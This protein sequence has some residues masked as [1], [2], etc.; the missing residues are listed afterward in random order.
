MG[1]CL[2]L[3]RALA[4]VVIFGSKSHG[5][6]EKML[7]SQIRDYCLK[8]RVRVTL[9]LAVYHQ[10]VRPGTK[11][12]ETHDQYFLFQLNTCGYSP[13]VTSSLMRGWV[14]CLQLPLVLASTV[15]LG[16]KFRGIHDHILLSQIRDSPN[17]EGQVPVFISPRNRLAQLYP[18]PM[19]SLFIASYDSRGYGLGIPTCTDRIENTASNSSFIVAFVYALPQ[20][21]VYR[22]FPSNGHLFWLHNSDFKR[23]CYNIL[24]P[25]IPY[26]YK[27]MWNEFAELH[28]QVD[29]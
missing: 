29:S 10:S 24:L 15:I 13:Y 23:T 25:I 27:R 11:P 17:L 7:L 6:H 21:R 16:S 18:Q 20:K 8:V 4:S 28:I 3:L 22:P 14:L 19:G 9:Q 2:Q 12:L 5:T 26:F 1:L